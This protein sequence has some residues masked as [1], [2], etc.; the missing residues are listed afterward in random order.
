MYIQKSIEKF[1]YKALYDFLNTF[2][3]QVNKK[4]TEFEDYFVLL[5]F[6][7][8]SEFLVKFGSIKVLNFYFTLFSIE[9]S[10]IN[11]L[12]ISCYETFEIHLRERLS[13]II[14]MNTATITDFFYML[15]VMY[16]PRF[17]TANFYDEMIKDQRVR[18]TKQLFLPAQVKIIDELERSITAGSKSIGIGPDTRFS[19]Y[20]SFQSDYLK[21]NILLMKDVSLHLL[22]HF[23]A[24]EN[25][26]L[27][28]IYPTSRKLCTTELLT[29]Y[30][31]VKYFLEYF[32]Q[33]ELRETNYNVRDLVQSYPRYLHSFI[34][35]QKEDL[36]VRQFI[37]KFFVLFKTN[38]C[39]FINNEKEFSLFTDTDNPFWVYMSEELKFWDIKTEESKVKF[40]QAFDNPEEEFDYCNFENV[41]NNYLHFVKTT[42]NVKDIKFSTNGTFLS[43]IN[44]LKQDNCLDIVYEAELDYINEFLTRTHHPVDTEFCKKY[45]E[46][47]FVKKAKYIRGFTI[48]KDNLF[49]KMSKIFKK[50]DRNTL[51]IHNMEKLEFSDEDD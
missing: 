21:F 20:H 43:Y 22:T 42:P 1:H 24:L 26:Y 40:I 36:K 18:R 29:F 41:N 33:D 10:Y 19:E 28:G 45:Y 50:V 4:N 11:P 14:F 30:S 13:M 49:N 51:T 35:V 7:L 12:N 37:D 34:E 9:Y 23:E 32:V 47:T 8:K 44:Y 48:T 16:T 15:L 39:W 25:Q 31:Q 2:L 5:Y 38:M 6:Q 17:I 27:E 3:F 46:K